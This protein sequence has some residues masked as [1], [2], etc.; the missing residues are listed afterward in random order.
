MSNPPFVI[1]GLDDLTRELS[2]LPEAI[3]SDLFPLS[4]REKYFDLARS[5]RHMMVGQ[6]VPLSIDDNTRS[7]PLHLPLEFL[8]HLGSVEEA[9]EKRIVG[10]GQEWIGYFLALRDFDMCHDRNVLLGHPNNRR[11]QIKGL[12][13]FRRLHDPSSMNGCRKE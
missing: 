3:V 6:D 5:T 10:E 4:V 7:Q 13:F 1:T 8:R 9:P 12:R 2:A 11:A